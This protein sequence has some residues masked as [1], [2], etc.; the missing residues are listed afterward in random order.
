M[1]DCDKSA[2]ASHEAG[3]DTSAVPSP[4]PPP[5][6]SADPNLRFIPSP[7]SD[8]SPTLAAQVDD[9]YKIAPVAALRMLSAGIEALV[10]M[11]GDIPPTPP[12]R[13]PTMPHMR[14]MEAE[15]K[16]IVRSNSDKNL[17]RLAQQRSAANSPRPSPRPGRSPL[18][19]DAKAASVPV[20]DGA[21][22][23]D[24]VQLR[25]PYP[26]Q[27]SRAEQ[28]LAPYI[29]VGENSQPLNLQHS[30]ITRKFYSR[31]PPPISI[32][33]YLLR[34]HRFCPMSTAVYLATS[35][36]IHRL[37]VLERAIAITKRNAHR[38]LLAGLRVAMKA[39]EDLSYAHGK[40]AKV[41]GVSEAE[42]AR[43]EISFCFLTGFELVVTYESLSKHWEMLRRGTDCW[44]LHD[45]LMEED[46]TVLQFAKPPKPRREH[47]VST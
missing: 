2:D 41:G 42:L 5:V 40:V 38:L 28:P 16:S 10:N 1:T 22:S 30:A 46:M 6:P 12:P 29:V 43:L 19:S 47:A 17:A 45:E 14:G 15:K 23:I 18:H 25:A 26:T 32:T 34:I 7:E 4:P 21:Q 31:L 39:L 9:I 8:A 3:S 20:P 24:G 44:N 36:Y 33:E 35:L 27:A 37:A 13:S 11:T